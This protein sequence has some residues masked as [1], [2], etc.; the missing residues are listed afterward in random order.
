MNH[1]RF[2]FK[3]DPL[4]QRKVTITFAVPVVEGDLSEA[5]I[6]TLLRDALYEFV[7]R[8][9]ERM[10]PRRSPEEYVNSSYPNFDGELLTRKIAEVKRRVDFATKTSQTIISV[11]SKVEP[12]PGDE[13]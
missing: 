2:P 10:V 8:G 5:E 6:I 7:N 3:T 9:S 11:I 4:S 13:T 1:N 12:I